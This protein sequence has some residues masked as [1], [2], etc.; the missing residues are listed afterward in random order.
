MKR[1][2]VEETRFM[3]NRMERVPENSLSLLSFSVPF[4][5]QKV[6]ILESVSSDGFIIKKIEEKT[7]VFLFTKSV[8]L[9]V[10]VSYIIFTKFGKS[11][12]ESNQVNKSEVKIKPLTVCDNIHNPFVVISFACF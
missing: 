4:F 8:E 2:S 9:R 12:V 11:Q 3:D 7:I 1:L 5:I 10:I 6:F